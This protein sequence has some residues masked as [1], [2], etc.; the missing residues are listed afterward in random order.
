MRQFA[1]AEKVYG[2][3]I[4]LLPDQPIL[5][6]QKAFN[7]TFMNTGDGTAFR[8][9]IAAL[10]ASLADDRNV[11][12]LRLCFT[13][14]DR[15]WTEANGLIQKMKDGE[16]D[17]YFAYAAISVPIDCYSLLLAR[18]QGEQPDA[19]PVSTKTREQLSQKVVKSPGNAQLLS[20]L[21]VVDALLSKKEAAIEEAKRAI[22]MLP[23]SLDAVDG[24]GLV[25]N[26]AVVYAWVGEPDLAF[27]TL[28]PL[29]R[30]PGGIFYGQLKRETYW[31][32][33]R[34]DPRFEELLAELAPR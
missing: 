29:T 4:G 23:I 18:L 3:L 9:A 11:L 27:E 5:E 14:N 26:L 6:V 16:D 20:Q 28:R 21:A 7:V 2:R 8:S 10:P 12:S 31:D 19:N 32:P 13:L 1:A 22:E 24:P 30:V 17:G 15:D 33:L 25:I 34:N